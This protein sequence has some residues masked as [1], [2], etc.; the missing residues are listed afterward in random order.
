MRAGLPQT[1]E[2]EWVK[3][4][5][6]RGT[7]WAPL[8]VFGLTVLFSAL[9]SAGFTTEG[10]SPDRPG[11][12]DVVV[13]GLL[14]VYVGQLIAAALAVLAIGSEYG[15]GTIRLT[16]A[17]NPRRRT[18]LAAKALLVAAVVLVAG[19]AASFASFL[20]A[21][22]ILHG[23]GFTAANGYPAASLADG[24]TLRAVVGTGVYLA[25]IALLALGVGAIL[26]NTAA[27]VSVMAGLVFIP[28]IMLGVLPERIG[29]WVERLCPTTAGLAIQHTVQDGPIDPWPGL[30]VLCAY[31]AVALLAALW[32]IARRDA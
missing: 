16:L 15:T 13:I 30:G 3:L 29:E 18:V 14:G 31:A 28:S 17:A 24:A 4:R 5:S 2:A 9:F 27:G 8:G 7:A 26:R 11:D 12:E 19:V 20:V 1:L 10:G 32:L 22:P 6:V 25:A 23:N 21:Q